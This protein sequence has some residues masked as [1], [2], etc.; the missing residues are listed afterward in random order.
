MDPRLGY[1]ILRH[2]RVAYEARPKI[3]AEERLKLWHR[4]N[5]SLPFRR[6][7]RQRLH[8]FAEEIRGGS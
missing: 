7:E 3:W 8:E 2:G 4:Y 6:A 1:E 5:D